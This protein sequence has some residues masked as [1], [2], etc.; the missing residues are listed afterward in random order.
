MD[1]IPI[2]LINTGRLVSLSL[3]MYIFVISFHLLFINHKDRR[4]KRF[5]LFQSVFGIMIS[6]YWI[7]ISIHKCILLFPLHDFFYRNAYF[8]GI[9]AMLMYIGLSLNKKLNEILNIK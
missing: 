3:C 1:D 9:F 4:D 8:F 5:T 7:I 2:L 6:L